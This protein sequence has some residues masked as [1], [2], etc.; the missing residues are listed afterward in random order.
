MAANINFKINFKDVMVKDLSFS[1]AK[2]A[3]SLTFNVVKATLFFPLVGIIMGIFLLA[4]SLPKPT[5]QL[6]FLRLI[7]LG[8]GQHR[9]PRIVILSLCSAGLGLFL[10]PFAIAGTVIKVKEKSREHF[11]ASL[12][13][14]KQTNEIPQDYLL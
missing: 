8:E 7:I 10:L 9:I 13:A 12:L 11:D 1:T 2:G 3:S 6:N 5:H 4:I 14:G